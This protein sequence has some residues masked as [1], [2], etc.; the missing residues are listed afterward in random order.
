ME[1][2]ELTIKQENFCQ[3]FITLGDKSKAYRE[4]YDAGSMN[5]NSVAVAAQEVFRVPN[6]SL[7]I[8]FLQKELRERN[9][10]KIDDVLE[11]LTDMIK[12]DISE[13]YDE[14]DNLKSI[15]EIPKQHRQM[16]S[17]L[18]TFEEFQGSGMQREL[19][20]YT[21]E[22]KTLNKLDVIE[23]FMKHLGGYEKDNMQKA[24]ETKSIPIVLSDGKSY[25]DL[26]KELE[27]E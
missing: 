8:E 26:K 11:V 9:K 13:L 14:N 2:T 4:A 22:V 24:T 3:A 10:I 16:I 7:R 27:P 18:K 6:V 17:S 20:G 5:T 25:D 19:I 1:S 15:H 23:K 12:F 21:K